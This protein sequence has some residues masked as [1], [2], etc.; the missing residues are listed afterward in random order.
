AKRGRARTLMQ[1]GRDSEALK[2]FNE[3]LKLDAN[4]A[5]SFANRAILED[6]MGF[7]KKAIKDYDR[8]IK[9]D[10]K[11]GKG[12]DWFTRLLQN[13]KEDTQ[14]LPERLEVLRDKIKAQSKPLP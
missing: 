5:V 6:R 9:M 2:A 8:A 10:P 11:L 1:L 7:Y 4:S 13:R 12:I 14:T 3:V